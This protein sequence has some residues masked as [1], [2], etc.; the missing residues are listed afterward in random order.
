MSEVFDAADKGGLSKKVA[1]LLRLI[2]RLG[3]NR[4]LECLHSCVDR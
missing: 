2:L 3:L 4:F 1:E